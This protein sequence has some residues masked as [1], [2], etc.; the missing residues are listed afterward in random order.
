[1]S[2]FTQQKMAAIRERVR[3]YQNGRKKHVPDGLVDVDLKVLHDAVN[4]LTLPLATPPVPDWMRRKV[5]DK[6]DYNH[7]TD[8]SR[9]II[10]SSLI[11]S[12]EVEK[13]KRLRA[14]NGDP[15]FPERLT[16]Y[17]QAVYEEYHSN[18]LEGDDLFDALTLDL[19]NRV[20]K[21]KARKGVYA[22]LAHLFELCRV[23]EK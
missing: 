4:C 6:M 11:Y 21:Q 10:T 13:F 18:G 19:E 3:T 22:I 14:A 1:M 12:G 9:E 8:D 17:F 7:L 5:E 2:A 23:F 20:Q 15:T 16:Q